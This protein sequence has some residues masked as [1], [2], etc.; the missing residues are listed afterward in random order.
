MYIFIDE[1]GDCGTKSTSATYFAITAVLLESEDEVHACETLIQSIRT[2]ACLSRRF[3]FHFRNIGH[4]HRIGF[5]NAVS[6][7]PFSYATCLL[8]KSP[9]IEREKADLY[10]HVL[11]GLV[12]ELREMLLIARAC[13]EGPLAGKVT[14]DDNEDPVYFRA[15][16][17]QFRLCR[18]EEGRSMIGKIRS[19][20]SHTSDILQLADMVCGAIVQSY[21]GEDVYRRI[22]ASKE[23]AY[24]ILNKENDE[25]DP[26][27]D[28]P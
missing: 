13:K 27:S 15:L 8:E 25:G 6:K 23:I 12:A 4:A 24:R 16:R 17:E 7:M 22:I 14:A 19:G 21:H 1:S 9:T 28:R 11:A 10:Q 3:E 26:N 2:D 18:D 5:L 20:R